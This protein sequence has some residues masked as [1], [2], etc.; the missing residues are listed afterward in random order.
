[1]RFQ[2]AFELLQ[3][4]HVKISYKQFGFFEPCQKVVNKWPWVTQEDPKK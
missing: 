2:T 4:V 1:M 3:M